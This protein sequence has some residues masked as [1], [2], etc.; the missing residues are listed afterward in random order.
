MRKNA[1][2]FVMALTKR[3]K[4]FPVSSHEVLYTKSLS[5]YFGL[6]LVKNGLK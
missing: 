1:K 3:G 5:S 2:L 6:K 4:F